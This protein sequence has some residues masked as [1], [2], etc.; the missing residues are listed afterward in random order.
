[1]IVDQI[2]HKV[3]EPG[4]L[5]L[6]LEKPAEKFKTLLAEVVSKQL[7]R[8]QGLVA[9]KRLSEQSKTKV[10]D[11]VV[12]HID[13]NQAL[14]DSDCLCHGFCAVVRTFVIRKMKRL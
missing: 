4:V 1:M 12:C 8:H 6:A 14:V 7:K 2:D 11:L 13:V 10:V 9:C 5:T 3:R